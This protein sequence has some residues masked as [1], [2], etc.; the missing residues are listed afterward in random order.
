MRQVEEFRG[1][2]HVVMESGLPLE[3]IDAL[4]D[5][6]ECIFGLKERDQLSI[7]TFN[8]RDRIP[9]VLEFV[10]ARE[11]ADAARQLL[12]T[13]RLRLWQE[14]LIV[15]APLIGTES[16][17]HQ[18][19]SYWPMQTASAV[20]CWIP[21]HDV[22]TTTGC[23]K[24]FSGSHR[25]GNPPSVLPRTLAELHELSE[26]HWGSAGA[27]H[28][29]ADQPMVRGECSF[30]H[31][32]VFHGASPNTSPSHRI[33]FKVVYMADGTRYRE[34]SHALTL[35]TGFRNGDAIEGDMFPLLRDP[36]AA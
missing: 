9:E 35:G 15:K 6:V 8:V 14:Q 5:R 16:G 24:F 28:G 31:G 2:G 18:D 26:S 13:S 29:P 3:L 21:L 4:R 20:T 22:D 12:G 11:I 33:V 10:F 7:S 30:H 25:W 19:F 23:L 36:A 32:L 1:K 34:Q 17:W 27:E